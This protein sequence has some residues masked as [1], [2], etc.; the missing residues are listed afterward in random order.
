MKKKYYIPDKSVMII[1]CLF[2]FILGLPA[3]YLEI[4][5]LYATFS[6]ILEASLEDTVTRIAMAILMILPMLLI[7]HTIS[8]CLCYTII[9]DKDKIYIHE[10]TNLKKAK[11]Q[12]YTCAYYNEIDSIDIF[13]SNRKSNGK[14]SSEH[15]I[16]GGSEKISYLRIKTKSN[17]QKLF[18]IMFTSK[19]T[20]KNIIIELKQRI[21]ACGNNIKIEDVDLIT[22]S[23]KW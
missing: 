6:H 2:L 7:G 13:L 17:E 9:L 15:S 14:R 10:D 1:S 11:I 5:I 20:V 19:K 21:E 22:Q 4:M 16:T 23:L 3:V 8:K 12:Y 18:M